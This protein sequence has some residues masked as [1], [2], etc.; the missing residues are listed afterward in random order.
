MI[1]PTLLAKQPSSVEL[2]VLGQ[3]DSA[4]VGL[5]EHHLPNLEV[6]GLDNKGSICVNSIP[7]GERTF[8]KRA[9]RGRL[10]ITPSSKHP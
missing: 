2:G 10:L 4:L 9:D 7:G 6:C 8:A 5:A 3:M 1:T